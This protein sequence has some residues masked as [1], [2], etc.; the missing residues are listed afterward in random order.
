MAIPLKSEQLV[1]ARSS[2]W[3][4]PTVILKNVQ[5]PTLLAEFALLYFLPLFPLSENI[6]RSFLSYRT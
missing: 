6:F 5:L 1:M 4:S 3:P 2:E